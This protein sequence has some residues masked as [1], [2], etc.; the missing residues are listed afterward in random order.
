MFQA[1]RVAPSP[2]KEGGALLQERLVAVVAAPVGQRSAHSFSSA[3]P[4]I[5]SFWALVS[6][7]YRPPHSFLV[8][9]ASADKRTNEGRDGHCPARARVPLARAWLSHARAR[10]RAPLLLR[11]FPRERRRRRQ[12]PLRVVKEQVE[13][14][15]SGRLFILVMALTCRETLWPSAKRS[16]YE[17]EED[18][19][20]LD[21]GVRSLEDPCLLK[22]DRVLH[23][24]LEAAEARW[25]GADPLAAQ[26]ELKPHMRKIVADWMLEVTE[27][28]RCQQEVFALAVDYLDRVLAR[29]PVAKNQFQV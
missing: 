15:A 8:Q 27:E 5:P 26:P 20:G 24:A 4:L 2:K 6:F 12:P 13:A 23:N 10:E 28:Q 11:L 25:T 14:A 1:L 7:F 16:R 19:L 21:G 17:D 9:R 29:F 18:D 3:A 22:D